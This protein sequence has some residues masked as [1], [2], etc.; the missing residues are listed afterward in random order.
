MSRDTG[1]A[2]STLCVKVNEISPLMKW[3][4]HELTPEEEDKLVILIIE[5]AERRFGEES[6]R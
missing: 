3:H 2:Q 4:M 6:V 5:C 1:I